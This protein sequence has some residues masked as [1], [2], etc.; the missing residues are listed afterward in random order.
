MM[1]TSGR[2]DNRA[3]PLQESDEGYEVA[4]RAVLQKIARFAYAAPALALLAQPKRAQAEYGGGGRNDG[5]GG[6]DRGGGSGG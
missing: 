1:T 5:G 6:N 2:D 4:R 3:T